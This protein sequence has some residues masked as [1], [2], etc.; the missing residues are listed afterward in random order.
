M[1]RA[2]WLPVLLV[3][4]QPAVAEPRIGVRGGDHPGHGRVVLDWP[5][6]VEY[7]V[8]EQAG[9]VVLRFAA[10]GMI[11]TG[12]LRRM[13]RNV[14][15]LEVVEGGIAI[16]VAPGVRPRH[17]RLDNRIVVDLPDPASPPR[18]A[19][20]RV[21]PNIAPPAA[22]A[23]PTQTAAP[24]PAVVAAAP[25]AAPLATPPPAAPTP[26]VPG[27]RVAEGALL[28]PAG[29]EVGGAMV[30]RGGNWLVVLDAALPL[31]AVGLRGDPRF[32]RLE[33]RSGPRATVLRVPA[34]DLAHP[35]LTRVAAG[36]QLAAMDVAAPLR[37]ILPEAE[38]GG[39]N[40]LSLRAEQP[41]E[42][43]PILDPE[44]GATLLV[45]TVRAG[46]EAVPVARRAASF[47]MLQTQLGVAV[48]PRA[49]TLSLRALADRFVLDGGAA[50]LGLGP[51]MPR[52]AAAAGMSRIFD[53]PAEELDALWARERAAMLAVAA[54][55]PLGRAAPRLRA[56]EAL[57]A[58]GLGQE[59][60][61]MAA[62]AMREDPRTASD[63]QAVA[64][65]AAAALVGGR[66]E[67]AAA[68]S[69]AAPATD[70]A[71]LWQAL[72]AAAR[73]EAAPRLV[74]KL[75]LL[76]SYPGPLRRRLEPVAAEALA[77]GGEV[78]AARRIIAASPEA[79][80]AFDLARARMQEAEGAIEAALAGYEAV[81]RGRD[82]RARARALR[83][84]A[85]LR[86]ASGRTDA[87][88]AAAAME[89]ALGAWRGDGLESAARL[90]VAELR[91]AAGESRAAFDLLRET[92][93][94][95]PA[96]APT[97][98]PLQA[99]ALREALAQ[100][101][102]RDAV[103]LFDQ[104]A[105][106]LPPDG[107]TSQV[108]ML[109]ADRLKALD[110]VDRA[111]A[112]LR[113]ALARTSGA[114]AR[115]MIGARLAGLALEANDPAGARAA[116]ADTAA[117]E[118]PQPLRQQRALLAARAL[119]RQGVMVDAV[120]AYREAGDA[121]APELAEFLAERQDWPQ[122]AAVLGAHLQAVLPAAPLPLYAAQQRLVARQ[123]A[124]LALAGQQDALRALHAAHGA[125]METGAMAD[126]FAL[127]TGDRMVAVADLPRLRQEL[128]LARALPSRLDSL[129][130][131]TPIAR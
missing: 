82:R 60:Q 15:G 38:A 81:T 11:E 42:A 22:P 2:A 115:A 9:R 61:A 12:Q 67:E 72:H 107:E 40:R 114:E 6:R 113:G 51:E 47:E 18:A 112:V 90:R 88:G 66:L 39:T 30:L 46:G 84:A 36:W 21:V 75:P 53:L 69:A 19:A 17:F 123:A 4:S 37:S 110:L 27:L 76:L 95:F 120:A 65:H 130:E 26:G 111:G 24:A 96:L 34:A 41:A 79:D 33:L 5:S 80:A 13:P 86:L 87:A 78:A 92:E 48:L 20:A 102:P 97:L 125:R 124:L 55:P 54:A 50:P 104:H 89:A 117:A 74:A 119:A 108:L 25:A 105:P 85:E 1:R 94:F 32:G 71:A 23:R 63:P 126:A 58:L 62:L 52:Q 121:A 91:R 116:L 100:A 14:T 93:A 16:L 131:M 98:R 59:A 49:D 44:T 101:A 10:P 3:L 45:G 70:E 28:V 109:L 77:A 68:L 73:G 64:L 83:Y 128:D 103:M 29:A 106:Q 57:L 43:V 122:A 35:R 129:R 7:R 127:L 8:E 56:A 31:D 118:L 99:A